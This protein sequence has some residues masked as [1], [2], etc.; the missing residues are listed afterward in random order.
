MDSL[1][2]SEIKKPVQTLGERWGGWLEALCQDPEWE[3]AAIAHPDRVYD[4]IIV[5]LER[6][7]TVRAVLELVWDFCPKRDPERLAD[8]LC[9][10]L[11]DQLTKATED[12]V[13]WSEGA[14]VETLVKNGSVEAMQFLYDKI[15]QRL[16][17]D[18]AGCLRLEH[19]A[20]YNRVAMVQWLLKKHPWPINQFEF[21]T[22]VALHAGSSE[23]VLA[24]LEWYQTTTQPALAKFLF[25][26]IFAEAQVRCNTKVL[27]WLLRHHSA[28][29]KPALY[30]GWFDTMVQTKSME[31]VELLLGLPLEPY[32][33]SNVALGVFATGD[34]DFTTWFLSQSGYRVTVGD[35]QAV[36][37][38]PFPRGPDVHRNTTKLPVVQHLVD[39]CSSPVAVH[40]YKELLDSAI[41]TCDTPVCNWLWTQ[42]GRPSRDTFT[43]RLGFTIGMTSAL[44]NLRLD[45]ARWLLTEFGEP[46][47]RP[48]FYLDLFR[49][50][51]TLPAV[52]FCL[53]HGADFGSIEQQMLDFTHALVRELFDHADLLLQF[54]PRLKDEL[55]LHVTRLIGMPYSQK[56]RSMLEWMLKTG[57]N[58]N[59]CP[60][61]LLVVFEQSDFELVTELI[62]KGVPLDEPTLHYLEQ[63]LLQDRLAVLE[64]N[65]EERNRFLTVWRRHVQPPP[66]ASM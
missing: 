56:I 57:V 18:Y 40:H 54:F 12:G 14:F 33:L 34:L 66:T 3:A 43:E 19:A 31:L 28:D 2:E 50:K 64:Y 7:R 27:I 11:L 47:P 53:E 5:P 4:R 44:T 61:L 38:R 8:R 49:S 1:D 65:T 39:R 32:Q 36:V 55:P 22:K 17:T 37:L 60:G 20:Q 13:R 35:I 45:H 63:Q 51:D 16:F 42:A 26:M 23:A 9:S 30:E 10:P 46:L 15:Q 48:E 29:V 41:P 52:R 21:S 62:E 25:R 24:L 59:Q 6:A 58:L